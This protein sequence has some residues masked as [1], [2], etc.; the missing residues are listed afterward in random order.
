MSGDD[1]VLGT[2]A[3]ELQRLHFQHKAWVEQAFSLWQLGGLR[4]GHVVLDLG[5]GPGFTSFDLAQVV[6]PTGR[7][8]A[9]DQSNAFVAFLARERELRGLGQIEPSL[10]PV[11]TL[12]LAPESVD[13]V[14][15]RWLFCWLA[16]PEAVLARAARALRSGGVILLQEY[17][18]WAAM[19]HLPRDAAFDRTVEACMR[20][21]LAARACIDIAEK[22]PAL[23]ERCELTIERVRPIAR[24]GRVGSLEWRWL[25]GFFHNYLPKLVEGGLLTERELDDGL[26]AWDERGDTDE[27]LCFAPIMADIV[28]RKP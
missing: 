12:E 20:S 4:A 9:R 2:D 27:R 18:D 23:A 24:I 15:S 13:V 7:V 3:S 6:G 21:W 8:I 10:G 17:L 28:L 11:E 5:C 1:Y 25:S 22:L 19:K 14:Y 16:D 26:L